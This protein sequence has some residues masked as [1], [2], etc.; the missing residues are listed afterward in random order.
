[1]PVPFADSVARFMPSRQSSTVA[2]AMTLSA[3]S[4]PDYDPNIAFLSEGHLFALDA[5]ELSITDVQT[6]AITLLP[7]GDICSLRL[8]YEDIDYS[9]NNNIR[10]Y[11][12]AINEYWSITSRR[13]HRD[14][15]DKEA[16]LKYNVFIKKLHEKMQAANNTPCKYSTNMTG[17]DFK[18]VTL[19]LSVFIII[20]S[21]FCFLLCEQLLFR[22]NLLVI[23]VAFTLFSLFMIWRSLP[24]VYSPD[25][26]PKRFLS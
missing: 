25:E 14:F 3:V 15:W 8:D 24:T 6:R 2:S 9:R 1:M 12:C 20:M 13:L 11:F 5:N 22:P 7:Y 18:I 19:G 21:I 23:P 17:A 26:I 10:I 4:L 16:D